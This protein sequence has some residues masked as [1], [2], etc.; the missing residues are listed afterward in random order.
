MERRLTLGRV[1]GVYGIK[2]WVKLQSFTR[3]V[4]NLLEYRDVWIDRGGN[5]TGGFEAKLTEGRIHGGTLVAR[6]T[7]PDGQV[8]EDRDIA[9]GLIG[10]EIRV[11]RSRLPK[12]EE[13]EFY[14]FDLVGLVVR[15]VEGVVLGK[16][17]SVTSNGAQDVLVVQDGQT[18][19][20]IPF[21]QGPII[22]SVSLDAQ[23]IVA[24]W[25]P[26]Y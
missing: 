2:G 13:G 16:V 18:E 7:G 5:A 26:D 1:A 12:A 15:N 23:E 9:A 8:I 22:R 20:L 4:E 19:R 11:D 14:W 6:L 3:P 25:Q 10:S 17:D 24:D 21:V